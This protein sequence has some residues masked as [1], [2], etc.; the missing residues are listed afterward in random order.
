[1][2]ELTD[3][4][5]ALQTHIDGSRILEPSLD[6]R[7]SYE[8]FPGSTRYSP[9]RIAFGAAGLSSSIAAGGLLTEMVVETRRLEL[10]TLS[11]QRRCSSS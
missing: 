7:A 9:G 2:L 1:V 6:S 5:I 3:Q 11:L 10:L 4:G 8:S